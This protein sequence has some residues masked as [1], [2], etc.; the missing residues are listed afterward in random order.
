MPSNKIS[1]CIAILA[2]F[3]GSAFAQDSYK[4]RRLAG[5]EIASAR[6][7]SIVGELVVCQGGFADTYPCQLVDM[8]AFTSVSDLAAGLDTEAVVVNDLWGW[9]DPET[10]VEYV[11]IGTN[12][13]TSFVDISDSGNPTVIG[14]LPRHAGAFSSTWRDIKVYADHAFIVSDNAGAHGMQVFDLNQLRGVASPPMLFE[15]TQHYDEFDSAHNIAINEASGFA[16]VVGAGSGGTTCGGGLHMIDITTPTSPTFAGCFADAST[17]RRGTGY[18]HDAQ[19]VNYNGPDT[20]HAGKE[21]CIGSNETDISI[22]DVSDKQNPVAL[23]TGTYPDANYIHQG[24]LSDDH[25]YFFQDDETDE[26][27]LALSVTRTIIWDL[28][29]LD[30]PMVLTTYESPLGVIDH[31]QYVKGNLLYQSNYNGGLRIL[32]ITDPSNLVELAYFDTRP[33]TDEARFD[34]AW[35]NY[36]YFESGVI[37]VSSI[38]EGLFL[39]NSNVVIDTSID[40]PALPSPMLLTSPYPNPFLG[41]TTLTITYDKAQHA[42]V[43]VYNLLGR[44]VAVLLDQMVPARTPFNLTFSADQLPG[45]AYIIRASSEG[46]TETRVVTLVR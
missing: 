16:Y 26:R 10:G 14:Y 20:E 2:L 39:L 31:N 44:R 6:P 43:S 28:T 40:T 4:A 9:T 3:A 42:K 37:A 11:L 35:S 36:P 29:D 18:S 46:H 27:N 1:T 5:A 21:I 30:D 38:D 12:S 13:G 32:D 41:E 17:G 33:N 24:W 15:E 19:C 7:S 25:R 22:A 45:G 34:G 8:L 23:S